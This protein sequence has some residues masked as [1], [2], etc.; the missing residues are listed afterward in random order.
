M[1]QEVRVATA[2]FPVTIR[3]AVRTKVPV[4]FV[5]NV[6]VTEEKYVA[7]SEGTSLKVKVEN[8]MINIRFDVGF[9]VTWT[10][11][12]ALLV[13][14]SPLYSGLMCGLCGDF[15]G[16]RM[17]EFTT[18]DGTIVNEVQPFVRSYVAGIDECNV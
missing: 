15:N 16:Q 13:G 7:N 3:T 14:V 5:N 18:A 17:D 12:G 4:V 8:G 9:F 2:A 1:K 10:P 6:I 11:D